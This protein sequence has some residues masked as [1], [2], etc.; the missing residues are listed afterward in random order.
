MTEITKLSVEDLQSLRDSFTADETNRIAMNA[1]TAAGIDKV[2]KNYDRARLLQHRFSTIVDNGEVTHQ[3]RSGRCWL[4]S[5]LNVAR[6]VA[7]KNMDLEQF[8]FSQNYAMYYDKLERV[9]YFLKDMACLVEAG[10]PEDS[11]LVQHLLREVMGDGGQWTMAMNVYKKYGAVPKDLFPETESSKN[12]GEMNTQLRHLL[13]TA[14]AHMYAAKGD[15]AKVEQIIAETTAAGHRILTIHLGEPPVSFDWEWTDADGEFH[16]DGEITPV[17]FWKKYV[18]PAGLED[19]VCLVDDP[20]AEHAKG[21]KIGIEHLGNVAGGDATEYLNVPNQFMKDCVKQILV[22]Q[23]IPVWFGAECGP[24][25]DREAGAWATDLFEY[26]RV[27]GVRFDLSK[28]QRVRFG[29]SAMD[30]AMAF[31]GVDVADDGT[32]TRRWRVENSW[33]DKIADKGYFTMSDDW[34]TEYVYEVAVPKALLPEEYQKA[35]EE[36]AI[37]LPAWDPMGALA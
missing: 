15:T 18:G 1:V 9:N 2:A 37:S 23:G 7:K 36:P 24:M 29:D 22:E 6:F 34:F 27:Y 17:E 33:G 3:D 30:H 12:T 21:K 16:R 31:A 26:D 8:E 10:E 13:H 19:Y 35:L 25:M 4:F 20:R 14:V 11:C 32:T 28:E 5:S